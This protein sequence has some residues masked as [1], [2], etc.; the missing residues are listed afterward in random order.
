M[1][2]IIFYLVF[3]N[4]A[5]FI[6]ACSTGRGTILSDIGNGATEYRDIAGEIGDGQAELGI[7]GARIE[8]RSRELEQ[9]ISRGAET[10]QDIRTIIQQVRNRPVDADLIEKWRNSRIEARE[11]PGDTEERGI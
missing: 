4:L 2:K 5:L 3:I 10:I 9:S 6:S 1:R 8:E 11:S 7:T